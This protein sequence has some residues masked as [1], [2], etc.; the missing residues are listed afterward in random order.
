MSHPP[1]V[2]ERDRREPQP[3]ATQA[4]PAELTRLVARAATAP[5]PPP[6]LGPVAAGDDAAT[7][8]ATPPVRRASA[9]AEPGAY[10]EILGPDEL[11]RRESRAEPRPPGERGRPEPVPPVVIGQIDVHVAAPEPARDPF[12]GSRRLV[13]GVTSRRGGGW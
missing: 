9:P 11:A 5:V 8:R 1:A 10:R 2:H 6:G 4:D 12:A 3:V 13:A 7:V